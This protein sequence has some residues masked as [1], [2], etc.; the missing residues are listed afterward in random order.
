[1]NATL[2]DPSTDPLGIGKIPLLHSGQSHGNFRGCTGIQAVEPIG[3]M[4]LASGIYVFP[5]CDHWSNGNAD[6]TLVQD[7]S[8]LFC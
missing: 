2:Q 8:A 3:E 5:D 6:V 1:M 4:T 7:I